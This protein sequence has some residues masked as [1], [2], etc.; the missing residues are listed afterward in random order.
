MNFEQESHKSFFRCAH[1]LAN[2][3]I[4]Y[5]TNFDKLVELVVSCGGEGPGQDGKK[6]YV[7]FTCSCGGIH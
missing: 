1:F 6:R 2:E 7:L 5:S 4:P 3:H